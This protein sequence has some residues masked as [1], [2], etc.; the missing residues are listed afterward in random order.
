M[1]FIGEAMNALDTL[2]SSKRSASILRW[3]TLPFDA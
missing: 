3:A 1:N 2:S